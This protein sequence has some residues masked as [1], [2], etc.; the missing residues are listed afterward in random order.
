MARGIL[1]VAPGK[2]GHCPGLFLV[3]FTNGLLYKGC[4]RGSTMIRSTRDFWTGLIYLFFGVS[5]ILI[6]RDY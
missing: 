2:A 5:A 3:F 4:A 6:A 1:R